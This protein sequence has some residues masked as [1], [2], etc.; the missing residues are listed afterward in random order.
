MHKISFLLQ[1]TKVTKTFTWHPILSNNSNMKYSA[2]CIVQ[3][4]LYIVY[5][6]HKKMIFWF[7]LKY[8]EIFL[9]CINETL[10]SGTP[11]PQN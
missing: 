8:Y 4:M 1:F 2:I 7:T 3:V 11:Y 6:M 10:F 9:Q 5:Y